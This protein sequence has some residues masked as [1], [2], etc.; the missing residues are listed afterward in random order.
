MDIASLHMDQLEKRKCTVGMVCRGQLLRAYAFDSKWHNNLLQALI[1]RGLLPYEALQAPDRSATNPRTPKKPSPSKEE[2]LQALRCDLNMPSS[3]GASPSASL[4]VSPSKEEIMQA[5]QGDLMHELALDLRST[6]QKQTPQ[7]SAKCLWE[8]TPLS[9]D[10]L[11]FFAYHEDGEFFVE[12]FGGEEGRQDA[13]ERMDNARNMPVLAV[14]AKG[15][16]FRLESESP[17]WEGKLQDHLRC[18]ELLA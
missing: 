13:N 3:K 6:P 11:S 12:T 4:P 17:D 8:A 2:V 5:L 14:G 16:I 9:D 15:K 18:L 10:D 7:T 1:K